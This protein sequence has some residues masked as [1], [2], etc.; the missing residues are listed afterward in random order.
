MKIQVGLGAVWPTVLACLMMLAGCAGPV[1]F[2]SPLSQP[3]GSSRDQI[4][5]RLGSPTAILALPDGERLQYSSLPAGAT[6]YNLDLDSQGRLVRVDQ[7]LLRTRIDADMVVDETRAEQIRML[8]GSPIRIEKVG[9]FDGDVWVY[10]FIEL[11]EPY[12][13]YLHL[14]AQGVLR[15]IIYM[16]VR[17]PPSGRRH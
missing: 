17:N 5:E 1:L 12:F 6:V 9:R 15:R 4:F 7:P 16:Q 8:Y 3:I 10:T 14:D 13:A 2:R 11:N